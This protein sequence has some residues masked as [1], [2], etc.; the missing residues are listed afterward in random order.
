MRCRPLPVRL[1]DDLRRDLD[2]LVENT[3]REIGLPVTRT[4]FVINAIRH[5]VDIKKNGPRS[6]LL[7]RLDT[8]AAVRAASARLRK[9]GVTVDDVEAVV[10]SVL[11]SALE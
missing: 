4:A 11:D 3:G 5:Y 9:Y 2:E 7:C 1:P 6:R 10:A 8:D